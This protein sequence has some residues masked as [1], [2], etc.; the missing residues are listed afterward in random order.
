MRDEIGNTLNLI[1]EKLLNKTYIDYDVLKI[2]INQLYEIASDKLG[3]D[4][5]LLS[6]VI[7]TKQI[8]DNEEMK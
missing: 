8:I 1:K 7:N 2:E 4:D 5:E 3:K 6:E